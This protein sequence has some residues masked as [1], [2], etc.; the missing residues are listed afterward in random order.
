MKKYNIKVNRAEALRYLGYRGTAVDGVVESQLADAVSTLERVSEPSYIYKTCDIELIPAG[1]VQKAVKSAFPANPTAS[2][3]EELQAVALKGTAV[4]LTGKSAVTMLSDCSRCIMMAV[5]IGRRVDQAIHRAQVADMSG[6]VI[7][8]S[9]ASSAVESIC[10]QLQNDIEADYMSRGLYIT[11]RFSPG[12]GDLPI[13]LQPVICRA[14]SA[15]KMIGLTITSGMLMMPTKSVTAFIGISD[16]P[17]PKRLTGCAN[18]TMKKYCRYRKAGV[19]C[20]G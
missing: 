12:Y 2:G 7:M 19:T 13:D 10:D 3:K 18:C 14:L 11:D 20:A 17:Q 4:V 6:A 8:D 16:R 15:D 5:T 1:I 9:C